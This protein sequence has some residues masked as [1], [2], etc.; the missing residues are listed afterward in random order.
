MYPYCL[1]ADGFG[2]EEDPGQDVGDVRLSFGYY[3]S[4][5][6]QSN[7]ERRCN[8]LIS[9]ASV[10]RHASDKDRLTLKS[11]HMSSA[12]LYASD[13]QLRFGIRYLQGATAALLSIGHMLAIGSWLASAPA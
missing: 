10:Q 2:L 6:S 12:E 11:S 7:G 1:T 8:W 13:T 9:G 3:H 5:S 4:S